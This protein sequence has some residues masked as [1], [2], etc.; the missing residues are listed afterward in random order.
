MPAKPSSPSCRSVHNPRAH[1]RHFRKDDVVEILSETEIRGSLDGQETL[2]SLPFMPEM[3]KFC[4]RRCRVL[5]RLD[6]VYLD[7]H[8]RM[9]YLPDV[10]MLEGIRCDGSAHAGCQM[11]CFA[12]WKEAWLKPAQGTPDLPPPVALPLLSSV[13]GDCPNFRLCENGTVPLEKHGK[14]TFSCQATE[15]VRAVEPISP[16]AL[17][18]YARDLR[19]GD[20]SLFEL[21]RMASLMAANR[22]RRRFKR[23]LHGMTPGAL[24]STPAVSLDLQ[25][26]DL[27]RVKDREQI[28]AT[29][30]TVGR[31]RGLVFLPDM[32]R[33]CGQT[34]RV[35]RRIERA[36][37]DYT[38]QMKSFP[39]TVALEGVY[40]SGLS[41]GAC[42]RSCYHLWREAWLEKIDP[43]AN[44]D[45][46][47]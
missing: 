30:D 33:F 40:C 26:G 27:V 39:N 43:A 2:R 38:G 8:R 12:L 28:R 41:L 16:W 20:R 25:P 46:P 42:A 11:G 32:V 35:A 7:G 36:V 24:Q 31:N 5:N 21:A 44:A 18:R 10:V 15:L 19:D 45:G 47:A 1:R 37:I 22:I 9:G 23:R 17:W 34:F 29:L 4:G 14:E 13:A 6:K 3:A